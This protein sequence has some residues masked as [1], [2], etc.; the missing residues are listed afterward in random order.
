MKR[1]LHITDEE[2][3]PALNSVLGTTCAF[4]AGGIN[5][6]GFMAI[7]RYT[8]HVTGI[9]SESTLFLIQHNWV[10]AAQILGLVIGFGSGAAFAAYTIQLARYFKFKNPFAIALMSSGTTLLLLGLWAMHYG[11][12]HPHELLIEFGLFFAM[13]IQNATVTQLSNND[14]RATHMTGILT[15]LGIEIGKGL[16][17]RKT[18]DTAKLR[19][20]ALILLS[21]VTGGILGVFLFQS[22]LGIKSLLVYGG[23]LFALAAIPIVKDS[24]SS[25]IHHIKTHAIFKK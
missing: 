15:D 2:R 12:T 23:T 7:G 16:F 14:V 20:A 13:G 24:G 5:A 19:L 4:I 18:M 25:A 10:N 21:F 9:V 6:G 8:S 17:S 22:A 3:S 1:I 11:T